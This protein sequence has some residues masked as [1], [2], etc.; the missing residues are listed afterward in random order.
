MEDENPVF[1]D[2]QSSDK[3]LTI[4]I[5]IASF[6]VTAIS[7]SVLVLIGTYIPGQFIPRKSHIKHWY[8]CATFNSTINS[9]GLDCDC[10]RVLTGSV[11]VGLHQLFIEKHKF[12]TYLLSDTP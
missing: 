9:A 8:I 6:H 2:Y 10:A 11:R 1:R 7:V 5:V 3:S 4:Q 12:S